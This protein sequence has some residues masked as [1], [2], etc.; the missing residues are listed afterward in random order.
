MNE[1]RNNHLQTGDSCTHVISI[2][3][4]F[5]RRELGVGDAGVRGSEW[6][7]NN[8][9]SIRNLESKFSMPDFLQKYA[10]TKE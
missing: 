6:R 4:S 9:F 8:H 2:W 1:E 3:R 5:P 10:T 7:I